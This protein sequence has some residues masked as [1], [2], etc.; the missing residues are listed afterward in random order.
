MT[1]VERIWIIVC[2]CVF[3]AGWGQ[4]IAVLKYSGGGDWYSDPS[5]LPNLLRFIGAHTTVDVAGAPKAARQVDDRAVVHPALDH[6]VE[7]DWLKSS[8]ISSG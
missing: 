6:T 8:A 4:E 5:S 1:I 7:L 2:L 3:Q